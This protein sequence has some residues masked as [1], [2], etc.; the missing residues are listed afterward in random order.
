MSGQS[1][2]AERQAILD[3]MQVR[4]ERYRRM[5]TDGTSLDGAELVEVHPSHHYQSGHATTSLAPSSH[6]APHGL[7][8]AGLHGQRVAYRSDTPGSARHG[9]VIR[10]LMDHPFLCALGVA[11]IVAIG[12]RRIIRTLTRGGT[13]LSTFAG[14]PSNVDLAGRLLTMVGAY[15][16]GRTK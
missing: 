12:P 8:Y 9:A 1:L 6:D 16:Q 2:E 3:R 15:V 5:L 4:R 11:A 10:T 14:N 13:A 7:H